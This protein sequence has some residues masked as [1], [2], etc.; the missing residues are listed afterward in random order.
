M[1]STRIRQNGKKHITDGLIIAGPDEENKG[2]FNEN[3]IR[4]V[5]YL[6]ILKLIRA[7][8]RFTLNW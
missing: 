3:Q 4:T 1:D 5:G 7:I 6:K 2:T 8:L